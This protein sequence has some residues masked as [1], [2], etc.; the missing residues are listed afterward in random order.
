MFAGGA[1][2]DALA[3][4]HELLP[5][6]ACTTPSSSS[7]TEVETA[8]GI[9]LLPASIENRTTILSYPY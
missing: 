7:M 8:Q 5:V 9:S 2:L 3:Q 4:P 1:R 6:L